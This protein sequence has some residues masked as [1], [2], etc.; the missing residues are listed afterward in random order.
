MK[1]KSLIFCTLIGAFLSSTLFTSCEKDDTSSFKETNDIG[2]TAEQIKQKENLNS[3]ALIVLDI[4]DSKEIFNEVHSAVIISL[5][6]GLDEQYR[7]KD[8][9]YPTE[10]KIPS[11]KSTKIGNFGTKF[12]D[13][14]RTNRLKSTSSEDIETF[15][16]SE[17]VQIYWP[18]SQNW[19]GVSEPVITFDPIAYVDH[20]IGFKRV[21]QEDGSIRIDTVIVNDDYAY[22]NPVWIINFSESFYG[23]IENA[24]TSTQVHKWSIGYVRSTVQYDNIFNGGSEFMFMIIGGK[25]T[26]LSTAQAFESIVTVHLSRRDIRR[27][28][29]RRFYYELDDDW[30]VGPE[31][32]ELG[33]RFGLIEHDKNRTTRELKF[34]PKVVINGVT[35]SLGSYTIR[36]ES[37]EGWIRTDVFESR[38]TMMRNQHTNMGLGLIDGFRVHGA[39]GVYWTMPIR[40]F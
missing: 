9:L 25:L 21:L 27:G 40:V 24:V 14:I 33:R 38:N 36:T 12:R 28:T 31:N 8:I 1:N 20:N 32:K 34:E 17:D 16:L 5:N 29:F 30:R 19:D 6:Y 39:G 4:A 7:F 26:S 23:E 22:E 35:V 2:L 3:I 15:I 18:Y 13:A 11:L 37:N 10:S